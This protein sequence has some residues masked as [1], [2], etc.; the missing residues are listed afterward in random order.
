MLPVGI[1]KPTIPASERPQSYVFDR[2]V[3][4]TGQSLDYYYSLSKLPYPA[5]LVISLVTGNM[6]GGWRPHGRDAK[7][8][9]Q[10]IASFIEVEPL[11]VHHSTHTYFLLAA[12][13]F[14]KCSR[15]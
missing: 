10:Q 12:L 6:G 7:L 2:A 14:P 11:N 9:L 15:R 8:K 1:Q 5:F 13:I 3:T 4:G